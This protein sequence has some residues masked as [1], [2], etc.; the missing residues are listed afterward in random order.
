[1]N[2]QENIEA[3]KLKFEGDKIRLREEWDERLK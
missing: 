1:M 2:N 3:I